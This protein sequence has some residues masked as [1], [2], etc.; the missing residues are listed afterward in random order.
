MKNK[1]NRLLFV[2]AVLGDLFE[3]IN[4]PLG[5][6]SLPFKIVYGFTPHQYKKHHFLSAYYHATKNKN[7]E[8]VNKN[9]NACMQLTKKGKDRYIK[10]YPV[11]IF[12]KKKWD[13]KWRF[14][15]F[16]INEKRKRDRNLLRQKLLTWGFGKLQKSVYISPF[17]IEKGVREFLASAELD[18]EVKIF[19]SEK[20]NIQEAKLLSED[21]WTLS[22]INN[23]YFQIYKNIKEEKSSI[24]LRDLKAK[25][26]DLLLTDPKLPNKLLPFPWYKDNIVNWL[27][28]KS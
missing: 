23:K 22:V 10:S 4:N 5:L 9:G 28:L 20:V 25:F 14:V 7:L 18:N 13:R 3:G 11:S 2:L 1:R 24:K 17:P 21:I 15:I 27:R 26:I 6:C 19:I 12:N 8:K 16:D